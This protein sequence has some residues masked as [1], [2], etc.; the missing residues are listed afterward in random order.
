MNDP[1]KKYRLG[2][3]SKTILQEGLN[4]FHGAKQAFSA[5]DTVNSEIFASVLFSRNFA[6]ICKVSRN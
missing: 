5:L 2:T 3:V 1:Q 4:R 6:C